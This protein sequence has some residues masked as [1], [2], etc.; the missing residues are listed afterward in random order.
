MATKKSLTT[1]QAAVQLTRNDSSWSVNLKENTAITY[2]YRNSIPSNYQGDDIE[3]DTFSKFTAHQIKMTEIILDL[4][5]DIC[6][7]TFNRV[8]GTTGYSNNATI[9]LGNYSDPDESST[10]G[11]SYSV[12][13]GTRSAGSTDGDFWYNLNGPNDDGGPPNMD[14]GT[15]NYTTVM[16]ELG[17]SLGL[18]H[19]TDYPDDFDYARDASY[20]EDSLQYT[21]MSY[22]D[23]SNTGA[24]VQGQYFR[25]PGL[26][27]I[28]ALQRLYGANMET[29]TGNDTYGFGGQGVYK[30]S[31][32][33][34]K[35]VFSI[36][37]AGGN[38]TL[39]FS[40]YSNTQTID[41]N[42]DKFSSVGGLKFNISI[43]K[44]V[45]IENAIGGSG[46]D[47]IIGNS[48]ANL[49]DGRA[50]N[51]TLN[52]N[53]GNDR[54]IGGTGFDTMDGGRGIDIADYR[55]STTAI[56]VELN[57]STFVNVLRDDGTALDKI[58]NIENVYGG[59]GSDYLIGDALANRLVGGG[60][61]DVL[62]GAGGNDVLSGGS[63]NDTFL[64]GA[65][66]LLAL[67]LDLIL[68]FAKGDRIALVGDTFRAYDNKTGAIASASFSSGT[69]LK[70]MGKG[71]YL[72][73]DTDDAFIYYDTDGAGTGA[74]AIKFAELDNS[75]ILKSTDF[76]IV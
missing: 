71:D 70:S 61:A 42:A 73:F 59:S 33:S 23:A 26:H 66:S 40:L 34:E 53:D 20:R 22:F 21:M 37:D 55:T 54:L 65:A 14:V 48:A 45:T 58:K 11:Y 1:A 13:D 62:D 18:E 39:N 27:D 25:T 16:H 19:P 74:S 3:A 63:G 57:G 6:G 52:G 51:D 41:L 69:S 12:G 30:L 17:H 5:E 35:A 36:W 8:S 24:S 75:Y 50:G 29:R 43:A 49:L 64:F 76:L 72:F 47:T 60:G 7:I 68:D 15:D 10:Y 46:K 4:F 32:A 44:G 67:G 38:D 9:L 31:S 28:A 56:E 2:A